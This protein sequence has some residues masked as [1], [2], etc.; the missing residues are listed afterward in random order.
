[1]QE[2]N[3][4]RR[5]PIRINLLAEAQAA[6][7]ARRRD[8]VKLSAWIGGFLICL[9]A[10]WS[11]KLQCDIYFA[12]KTLRV[13]EAQ[14]SSLQRQYAEVLTNRALQ[15]RMEGKLASLDRLSTNRF[16]WGSV[17]DALQQTTID[18]IVIRSFK[19]SVVF[20]HVDFVPAS[21]TP[22]GRTILAVPP[23]SIEQ[24]A[25]TIDGRDFG[26]PEDQTYSKYK[27]AL[28]HFPFFLSR[29]SQGEGFTLDGSLGKL[30]ADPQDPSKRF[31]DFTLSCKFPE[32]RRNE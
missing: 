2:S 18:D 15:T 24:V 22:E 3:S 14:W 1:M 13:E 26:V 4:P 31:V 28:N 30:T 9:V 29:I 23:A 11:L 6:E 5:M 8:P 16:L 32:V 17:M 20:K 7:Q 12:G 21:K 25:V 27:D 19:G 10:L